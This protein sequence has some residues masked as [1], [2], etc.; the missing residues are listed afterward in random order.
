MAGVGGAV[1]KIWGEYYILKRINKKNVTC[2]WLLKIKHEPGRNFS[3]ERP[4]SSHSHRFL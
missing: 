2:A 4:S 3:L 1:V